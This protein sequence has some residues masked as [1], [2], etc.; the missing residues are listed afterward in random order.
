MIHL[1]YNIGN[2]IKKKGERDAKEMDFSRCCPIGSCCVFSVGRRKEGIRFRIGYVCKIGTMDWFLNEE[3]GIKDFCAMNDDCQ[4][5][6][7]VDANMNIEA[8]ISGVD[9]MISKGANALALVVPNPVIGPTIAD[10]AYAAGVKMITIDDPFQDKEGKYIPHVGMNGIQAGNIAG[11]KAVEYMKKKGLDKKTDGSVHIY[12]MAIDQI[13]PCKD[14]NNGFEN[15]VKKELPGWN[16]KRDYTRL[17]FS[18]G[19]AAIEDATNAAAQVIQAHPDAKIWIVYGCDDSS[20]VGASIAMT[21]RG[22]DTT[23][24]SIPQN[25][26]SPVITEWKKGNPY[27]K[28]SITQ[29]A[30]VHGWLGA[31]IL[32]DKIVKGAEPQKITYSPAI[33]ITPEDAKA[34][35]PDGRVTLGRPADMDK[36]IAG[37][38]AG[39]HYSLKDVKPDFRY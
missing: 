30:W 3:Q 1:A 2:S 26:A 38:L 23:S 11:Q 7:S 14:R 22:M 12:S 18:A 34:M 28:F 20:A 33:A 8:F 5:I 6:G 4:Y 31:Q 32:Y 10:K 21:E 37:R 29:Y 19:S 36:Q 25:G 13:P 17:D 27:I 24:I 9:Q 35:Y 16:W 39:K 15:I